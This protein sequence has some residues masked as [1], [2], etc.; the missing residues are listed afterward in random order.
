MRISL[1]IKPKLTLWYLLITALLIVL[2][3]IAAYFLLSQGLY[4]MTTHPW[5]IRVAHLEKV[6]GDSQ[7][8]TG[9]SNI[10]QQE[11]GAQMGGPVKA[12]RYSKKELLDSVSEQGTIIVENVIIGKAALDTLDISGSDS[13]WFYTYLTGE[14]ASVV[15]VTR[16]VNDVKAVLEAFRQVLLVLIPL[17]LVIAGVF[18]Y[19]LVKRS[20]RPVQA[21]TQTA[22]EIEEKDLNKRLAVT[23]KDE[24]G[25]LASTLNHMLTRL[26]D[27]FS[28]EKQ[29]TADAS[30]ELRTPLAV[31]QG[32]TTLALQKE[33]EATDYRKSLEIIARAA[34]HMSSITRQLLFLARDGGDR[35]FE[36]EDMNLA[37]FIAELTSDAEVLC[38]PKN[39]KIQVDVE[40]N[41]SVRGD[42]VTLREIFFNLI[43]NAIRYTPD[44]G[45]ICIRLSRKNNQ[46]CLAVKDSGVGIPKDHI[47]YIFERFYRVD[48]SRT[49]SG[50][51]S[52]LGLAICQRIAELHGG[53][54]S[55]ESKVGEGSIFSVWLPLASMLYKP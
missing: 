54:I 53:T 52:G 26:E 10:G 44:G 16:S 36:L 22:R 18:G 12:S 34:E 3:S 23:S 15:V 2:F 11:W 29:F 35:S 9:F 46:A 4:G 38:E 49:C 1:N 32:E 14:Q 42:K 8:I 41:L 55:V 47:K 48:K 51:G 20:L 21:I 50:G 31:V 45:S 27:A 43:D 6:E 19:F 24:L 25:Q 37:A 33:R 40:E 13:I 39:I 30:H 5:D 28:R 7:V 17:A